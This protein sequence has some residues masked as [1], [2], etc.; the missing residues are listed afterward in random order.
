MSEVDQAALDASLVEAFAKGRLPFCHD[1]SYR[2]KSSDRWMCS[3]S[4]AELQRCPAF[5][6]PEADA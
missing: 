2:L 6:G 1:P 5:K 3:L 4:Q